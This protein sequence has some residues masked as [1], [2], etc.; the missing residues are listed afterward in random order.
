MSTGTG[1]DETAI[2]A[3]TVVL[4][5]DGDDGLETLLVRRN[6]KLEFAGGM[7]VF[8]GGRI[9]AGDYLP[10]A[11]EDLMAAARRAAVREAAEEAGLRLQ[12][13]RLVAFSHWV[14]PPQ[15]PKR[16][17]TWFFIGA[18]PAGSVTVD[19]GEIRDHAWMRPNEA[20]ERRDSKDIELAPP[21]WISLHRLAG[22]PTVEEALADSAARGP[23][24]FA[25][26]IAF[27]D[28]AV[29]ALYAGDSGYQDLD[30]TRPGR[31][32]RLWMLES[33]WRYE[34]DG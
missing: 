6:S 2:P 18:E 29:V 24:F 21:T 5:R 4:V 23:E 31:R 19:G 14:P 26:R 17:S 16:F 30:A 1:A 15:A 13:D 20:L 22:Y 34:R 10:D 32:H 11:P 27:V 28:D 33:G 9:D 8:P 7:W 3:A 25:T 12:A